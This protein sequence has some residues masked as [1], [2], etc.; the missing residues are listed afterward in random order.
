MKSSE[1]Y[2]YRRIALDWSKEL[3]AD[4]SGIKVRYIDDF[5]AGFDVDKEIEDKIKSTINAGF[6]ELDS[7]EHYNCRILE[8]ALQLKNETSDRQKLY[9]I[10]HLEVELGK[11]QREILDSYTNN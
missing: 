7:I 3:L 5:E 4:K 9:R 6:K 2:V 11:L 10:S 1:V 8:L